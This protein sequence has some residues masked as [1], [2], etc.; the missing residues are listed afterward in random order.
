[1][2]TLGAVNEPYLHAFPSPEEF[3]PLL[4]TGKMTLA[5]VY[6]ATTPLTSWMM[7]F[8]GDPMYN[9][10][11]KNPKVKVEDLPELFRPML[12]PAP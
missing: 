2:G 7:T 11:A 4:M 10:Y 12:K 9:P 6:W 1:V 3:F 5:E 8:I